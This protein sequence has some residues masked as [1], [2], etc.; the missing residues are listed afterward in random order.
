MLKPAKRVLRLITLT[1][2][3][4]ALWAITMPTA[5]PDSP[6]ASALSD[7]AATPALAAGCGNRAC[8]T[9]AFATCQ[10]NAGTR[11]KLHVRNSIGCATIPC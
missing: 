2:L 7:L 3:L 4:G 10:N 9:S 5:P 6:Y 11:C 8:D 1:A